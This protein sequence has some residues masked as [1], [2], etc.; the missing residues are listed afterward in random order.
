MYS[1]GNF[2]GKFLYDLGVVY[3]GTGEFTEDKTVYEYYKVDT[4]TSEQV[5]EV[6]SK[7]PGAKIKG[8]SPEYAPELKRVAI[9]FPKRRQA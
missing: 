3:H 6:K 2:P 9:C 5:T 7:Y 4:I 1:R 8:V